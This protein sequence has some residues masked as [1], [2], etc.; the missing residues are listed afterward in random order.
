MVIQSLVAAIEVPLLRILMKSGSE[1]KIRNTYRRRRRGREIVKLKK[2]T[3]YVRV[4]NIVSA[5]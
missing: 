2:S 4:S 5:C 1:K 3:K